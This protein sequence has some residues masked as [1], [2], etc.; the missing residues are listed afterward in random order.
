MS[1]AQSDP[2]PST[3]WVTRP[4]RFPAEEDQ[5]RRGRLLTFPVVG[6]R[7]KPTPSTTSSHPLP[8]WTLA[9]VSA[10]ALLVTFAQAPGRIV[11]DTSLPLVMSPIATMSSA[12]H[13]WDPTLWSGSIDTLSFGYIFPMGAFYALGHVLHAPVWCT[14]RIWLALLLT[15]GFWGMVRLA[16]ALGIGNRRGRLL[17]A[18]AYCIAPIVVTW[19]PTTGTLLA[20]V[21]LPWVLIPLVRGSTDGSPR[22]AAFVSGVAVALMGGVNSAVVVATLPVGAVWLLTRQRGPR[23]RALLGWWVVALVMACFWWAAALA[24]DSR[25]GY[26]YLPYTET[27]SITTATG[28]LYEALRGASFWLDHYTLGGPLLPGA[29]TLVSSVVP[30]LATTILAALGLAGLVRR[31]PERLFL[32]ASLAVGVIVIAAGYGGALGGPAAHSVQNLIGGGTLAALRNVSKFSPDVSLPL[33]LGFASITSLPLRSRSRLISSQPPRLGIRLPAMAVVVTV[34]VIVAAAPFWR[35]QLYPTGSFTAIPGYWS[36]AARWLDA[37]QDHGTALLVPGAAS[38]EYTWG[39]PIQEPLSVLAST[40]WSVRSLIPVGS[41]GNDQVLDTVE[42]SL[43]Q[44]VAETHMADF[45]AREG[46]DYVVVRNDLDLAATGAPAPAQV[47]QVLAQT[48]GLRLV[49]SFGPVIS[50]KQSNPSGMSVYDDPLYPM[51]LRAVQIYRVVPPAPQVRTYP[52]SDPVLVSGSASSLL[53]LLDAGVLEGRAAILAGDIG[54]QAAKTAPGVSWA[55]TDGNQRRDVAFG[56][57]RNNES[58]DLGPGQRSSVAQPHVPQNIAVV[59]G[60]EHQTVAAPMGGASASASTFSSQSVSASTFSS[61]PLA[62][63]SAEGPTS[64]FDDDPGTAWVANATNDSIGQWAEISF[65]RSVDL[66]TITVRP[67]ADGSQ[68]PTVTAVTVTTARGSVRRRLHGGINTITV[69]RGPSTWLRVTLSRVEPARSRPL[70]GY[71]LGAGLTSVGIPGVQ[72]VPALRL[73]ADEVSSFATRGNRVTFAFSA[74]AA[75]ATLNL[76]Q[77]DDDDPL[78]VRRF[79]APAT[80]ALVMIGQA[81]PIPGPALSSLIPK[82]TS[83]VQVTASSALGQL[84]RFNASNLVAGT[85]APWIAGQNDGRPALTVSWSGE[86]TVSS[87]V[88]RLTTEASRPLRVQISS[89]AG[90]AVVSVSEHGGTLR[91][92]PMTTDSLTIRFVKVNRTVGQVPGSGTR[93]FLPVGLRQLSVPALGKVTATLP[94][95]QSADLSCGKGPSIRLD[96]RVLPT[97]VLGSVSD[98]ENLTPMGLVVCGG[99]IAV[100]K[101]DHVLVAGR[102]GGAFKVSSLQAI[103]AASLP[104]PAGRSVRITGPWTSASRSVQV[105]AGA[106]AYLAVAQNYNAGWQATLDGRPLRPARLDGWEQAWV[107]PGGRGGTVVMTMPADAWYRGALLLGAVLLALLAAFAT[108]AGGRRDYARSSERRLPPVAVLGALGFAVLV[109]VC[110]PVALVLLPLLY[111]G[112]RWGRTPLAFI[113]AGG[114][115]AAGIAVATSPGAPPGSAV[116][117]YGWPAQ[118][119]AS[120]AF[121]AV[122][123]GLAAR[124]GQRSTTAPSEN[125][126]DPARTF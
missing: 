12:L 10:C 35:G 58:Y 46:F 63:D 113:A 100:G 13:L 21:L 116:G 98:L 44:G 105:G 106:A 49:A 85:G 40:S 107:V 83:N 57:I 71:P 65:G 28:S 73:P 70:N 126:T 31:I 39:Q 117:A 64:A 8:R 67:L 89:P 60:T 101:G 96:G 52:V 25:F 97:K 2:D 80:A 59:A 93:I 15:T 104:D 9:I 68:R 118:A 92:P 121:A 74:P 14:E 3:A 124:D 125:H 76:G 30:I 11:S 87:I 94:P 6:D 27:A 18:V 24:I 120:I 4:G 36:Q 45:L 77:A 42:S 43:D 22:R 29:W 114:F 110:G 109:L 84:P 53:G 112:R 47:R 72:F 78:M 86:R 99:S 111:V 34:A 20:V 26:N 61:T 56:G 54:S 69:R 119:G 91:F 41:N 23:R 7:G 103:P 95:N 108:I 51:G 17:G 1:S 38:G 79:D 88:M 32:V 82:V 19:T 115:V 50:T 55:D 66:H 123:A 16:E 33:A 37:H 62:L 102:L 75:N 48:P 122:L 81:V 5:T 90:R